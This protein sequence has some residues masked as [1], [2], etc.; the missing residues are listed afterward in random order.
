M[1]NILEGKLES[2]IPRGRSR[3]Q[4]CDNIKEWTGYSIAEFTRL[5]RQRGE[6]RQISSQPWIQD[7]TVNKKDVQQ[8]II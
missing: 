3:A 7:G 6:W 5:A 8:L 1:K 2:K 4:W